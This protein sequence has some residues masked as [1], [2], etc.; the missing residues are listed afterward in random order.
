MFSI[1]ILHTWL[2]L[3]SKDVHKPMIQSFH[4][5]LLN[6]VYLD[7]L[8]VLFTCMLKTKMFSFGHGIMAAKPS[9]KNVRSGDKKASSVISSRRTVIEL[10][11]ISSVTK[12]T[13]NCINA[14]TSFTPSIKKC[15]NV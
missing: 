12:R 14:F 1:D 5:T 2:R 15:T 10:K 4:S 3:K 8:K 13:V 11:S 9:M 6:E 7:N